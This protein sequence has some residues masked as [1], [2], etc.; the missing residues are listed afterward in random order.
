MFDKGGHQGINFA[1]GWPGE[2]SFAEL[3]PDGTSLAVL[4]NS[5]DGV[6]FRQINDAAKQLLDRLDTLRLPSPSWQ[7]YG[8]G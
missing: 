6:R 8:F 4:I 2:Q 3:R 7:D 1:G 5:D